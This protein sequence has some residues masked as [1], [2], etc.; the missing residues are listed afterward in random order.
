M[1][2]ILTTL[3]S[4][5]SKFRKSCQIDLDNLANLAGVS[6]KELELIE[7]GNL[8]DLKIIAVKLISEALDVSIEDLF[9]GNEPYSDVQS[10]VRLER[11]NEENKMLVNKFIDHCLE[12]QALETH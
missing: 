4:N 6:L 5:I 9:L 8:T 3:G 10:L 11:L 7:S 12:E 1:T 2:D